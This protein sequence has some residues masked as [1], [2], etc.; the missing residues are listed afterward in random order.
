MGTPFSVKRSGGD[1]YLF[2][3]TPTNCCDSQT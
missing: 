2:G 1:H 3:L